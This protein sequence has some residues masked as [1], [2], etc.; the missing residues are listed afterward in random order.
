MLRLNDTPGKARKKE[1]LNC[2]EV[3]P[4]G[5]TAM[6]HVPRELELH[7]RTPVNANRSSADCRLRNARRRNVFVMGAEPVRR[8][9]NVRNSPARNGQNKARRKHVRFAFPK[10]LNEKQT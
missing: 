3:M 9:A 5:F 7:P 4:Q 6:N 10:S 8:G 1:G 2:D